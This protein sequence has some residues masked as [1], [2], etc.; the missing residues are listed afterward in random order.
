MHGKA[1]GS[2]NARQIHVLQIVGDPVGGIRKHVH[3]LISGFDRRSFK[4]S[5]A[6]SSAA[7]DAR[8]QEEIGQLSA[9]LE[10]VVALPI[11]K[12]P[13][14]SDLTNLW[15]LC[16]Y[17]RHAGV[18]I[19]HGH[20]AKAGLYARLVGRLT[21]AKVIY[22]PH[23]G[24][25][26]RMFSRWEDALYTFIERRLMR[27]TDYFICESNYTAKALFEK[28]GNEPRHWCVN[29]NGVDFPDSDR[30]PDL[31]LYE[32]AGSKQAIRLGV[33]GMLREQK[34][35]YY[36]LR[37]MA[38]LV[39]DGF[40][41]TLHLFGDGPDR[42]RLTSLKAQL[43]LDR[44]V[45][46]YGDVSTPELYMSAMDL[47]LI[48]SLFESFGYVAVEAMA[49]GKPIIASATGGLCEVLSDE[50][51]KLIPPGDADAL[52]KEI[53]NFMGKQS[54]FEMNAANALLQVK[55]RFSTKGMVHGVEKVYF[56]IL[57]RPELIC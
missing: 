14:P 53:G 32:L 9:M 42:E 52:G 57:N 1:D 18:D 6:Y 51:A 26:H 16:R 27:Y 35:Q 11:R 7:V 50:T 21:G 3:S 24:V 28:L 55:K 39:R 54:C 8:F 34:G 4:V 56:S 12:K 43:A 48:P 25:V 13:H 2:E 20:G 41:V 31:P 44:H 29:Y 38:G 23:G 22:T 47:I 33:F 45:F 37:A 36:A 10:K 46:F 40:D 5:Y 17:V 15:T 49:L 30:Q 19:V